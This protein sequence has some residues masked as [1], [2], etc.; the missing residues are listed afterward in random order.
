MPSYPVRTGDC[1]FEEFFELV[2]DGQKADLLDGVI[3]MASPDNTDAGD[4]TVW[5]TIVLGGFVDVKELGKIFVSRFAYRI[6]SKHGPEPD[7]GFVPKALLVRRR[8]G[9]IDGPPALAIE[10]VS[11]D[12]V[13]RDYIQKRAIYEQAGVREYWILD[14]DEGRATFLVLRKKRYKKVSPIK[15]IIQSEV[16]PGFHLDV[17]W[18]LSASRPSAYDVLRKLLEEQ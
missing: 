11:P 6:G 2:E 1:T 10:I 5:L 12:S 4:L 16:V 7:I 9:Y 13:Q 17:R 3:Y 15:N 8:R 18:L 14:P